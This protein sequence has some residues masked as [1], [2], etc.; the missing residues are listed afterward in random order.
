MTTISKPAIVLAPGAWHKVHLYSPLTSRL[1]RAGYQVYGIDYPS[2]DP[3]PTSLNFNPDV[4]VVRST[5]V[6]LAERGEDIVIVTHSVGGIIGS[7]AAKGLSKTERQREGTLGG[8]TRM[9]YM[10][11]FAN[12]E[13]VALYDAINGPADW[14]I[15][16]GLVVMPARPKEILYNLCPAEVAKDNMDQL[17]PFAKGVFESKPTYA[18]WKHIP[19]TFLVCENDN[20]IPLAAQE[21]ML[22]QDGANFDV[23]RCGA[24]HSPFLSMPDYTA[25]VVRRAAG[26]AISPRR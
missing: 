8:V 19:S 21:G 17:I 24:D 14:H 11:A 22:S 1:Q 20:A 6:D 23:V 12:P 3:N 10:S 7:E 2:T 26:E 13:G 18:A 4:A 5:L 15:I 25:D 9:I 16:N